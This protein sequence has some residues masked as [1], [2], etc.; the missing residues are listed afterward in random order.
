MCIRDSRGNR[1][2]RTAW[3]GWL[4]WQVSRPRSATSA[5][6]VDSAE[7]PAVLVNNTLDRQFEVDAPD[8]VWVTD[9][10]YIKTHE[11][12]QYLSV[13]IDGRRGND[14]PD[15]FLILLH[16]AACGRLVRAA[17]HDNRHGLAGLAGC[18]LA[19]QTQDHGD[20]PLRPGIAVHQPRVAAVPQSAQSGGQHEPPR[21]LP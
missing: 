21:Q 20:D 10:T 16:L 6:L 13:V 17:P 1:F 15:R 14:P 9:T 4:T 7:S 19:T 11:G 18:S 8:R 3:P 5:A 2:Q 12:W